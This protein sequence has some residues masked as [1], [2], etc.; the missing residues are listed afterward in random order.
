MLTAW[1]VILVAL[2]YVGVLFA[3]ASYGDRA[4]RRTAR[5]TPRPL[6]YALSLAVYCTSWAYFG[7][8]GL[9][10]STGYDFLPIYIGPVLMLTVGWPV[11]R[12][13]V[14]ISKR[15]NITSIADFISARYGKNQPLGALVAVIAV[16]GVI[17]YISLQ[18]KAVSF[19][20]TTLLPPEGEPG[21]G[22]DLALIVAIAMACFA[23]LFGTRHVDA[24]EHQRGLI[25]AIAV[26]SM[27]KLAAFLA[28]GIFAT[29]WL[30]GGIGP[31]L[32]RVAAA[33]AVSEVFGGGLEGGRWVTMTLLAMCAILL[34]P[35]QFHVAVVENTNVSDLR[36]AAWLFPLY[37]LAINIFV[38]PI[39][40]AGL[41]TFGGQEV[42][43]DTYV[44]A[45]P[46]ASDYRALTLVAFIGGLSAATAMVIVESV[47]LS[48]MLCNNVVLPLLV[49]YFGGRE[50]PFGDLGRHV[51]LI[52]RVAIAFILILAY[53][54]YEMIGATAAL[55]QSGLLTFAAV[56]QFAPAFFGGLLWRR[57]TAAGAMAGMLAGFAVWA[58]TLLMPSFIDAGWLS[59]ALL[60][61]GL[62]G[63]AFLRPRMLFHI[64]FDPLTHGV[65]WSLLFNTAAYV[66]VSFLREPSPIERLQASA[67]V[68][69]EIPASSPAFRLWRTA[70][71]VGELQ[72]AVARYLGEE[73]TQRAF[74]EF[75]RHRSAPVEAT[76][77]ADIR[78][79]R[80]AEHLL[81][82][83]I[84]AASS[85]L[86]LGLLLERRAGNR[87]GAISLLD[88]ASEAVQY[89]RDLLQS[90][91]DHVRQGIAVFDKNLNLIC[92][93]RQ[94]RHLL[95]LAPEFGR[96]G[97]PLDE[98]L[99]AVARR[100]GV[101]EADVDRVMKDRIGR[102]CKG[103]EPYHERL[104]AGTVLEVRASQMPDGGI[105]VT[106]A[107]MTERVTAAEELRQVNESLERRVAERTG[108]L[109][110]LNSELALAKAEADA[111]N[112]GK[113]RFIAAAS[114]D[115]L[116]PLNAAR[117]FT[118]SLVE[119]QNRSGTGRF[120]DDQ[121]VGNLDASLVAV[122]E[123]LAALLDI[124]RLD[125]GATK[126]EVSSFKIGE[127]LQALAVEMAP[128]ARDANVKLTAMPS[129]LV[130]RSDRKLL[131]R[132]VQNLL[133]NAVKYAS[134]KRVLVGCRRRNGAVRIEVHDTGLGIPADKLQAI[135][136]EFE[137][138]GQ[139]EG[140]PGLGLGLSI[141][142]RIARMLDHALEVQSEPGR[143]S[144]FSLTVPMSSTPAV[145]A[146]PPPIASRPGELAGTTVLV[147][148]NEDTILHGMTA[149]L[150]HWQMKVI[151]ARDGAEA[152]AALASSPSIA[153]IVADYHLER[154][155]G[156]ELIDHLRSRAGRTIP[157]ILITADRSRNVQDDAAERG[158]V[159]MRKPVRSAA[160]RAALSHLMTRP[161]AA[162]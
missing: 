78:T 20:L 14:E 92:W 9:A 143:G 122:E 153:V 12:A 89:S 47:A 8:V 139:A 13:I 96:V 152:S 39:A 142:E 162:E 108:E 49:R 63:L 140:T 64:D 70:V 123:I 151:T 50:H 141:V 69:T 146:P 83:A 35:R 53:T 32:D 135:F 126:P 25:L 144:I 74:D 31:L 134:G 77:D 54:Y 41:L 100:T 22:S 120:V 21:A 98:I 150:G 129:S 104:A 52:R 58:Y 132:I 2:A 23:A 10:A 99:G 5:G 38:V 124:S 119:R 33:P 106:F 48:I 115:I 80:F 149:L 112:L 87:R 73:R 97:V 71:S 59:P 28:V 62:F 121:L 36:R 46:A 154:E 82:S 128:A 157:A 7:S 37:L 19:S 30:M 131:R 95:G 156:L 24:T 159:H 160:L 130:V 56:V 11:V 81:A 68:P 90:A 43:A 27:V 102:L 145:A 16:I 110:K 85:R 61:H 88:D 114:H 94:F 75:A 86:A 136:L 155:N 34:L 60:D 79:L 147:V 93:N 3:I 138:L 117:L 105:V 76:A 40:M 113:T 4:A 111:A 161:E 137:R 29:F 148:D 101:D 103:H 107:D 84:G 17:P 55:A 127:L 91:I 15:Q 118:S 51:L 125:A 158:V 42:D 109:V 6:I 44:L 1:T 57:G 72:A 133:S 67:F 26:E 66:A 18:L 116:Q 45:L 65:L